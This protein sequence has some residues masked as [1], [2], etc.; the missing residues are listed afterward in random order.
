MSNEEQK[1][2]YIKPILVAVVDKQI[3]Q[4]SKMQVELLGTEINP[5]DYNNIS[6]MIGNLKEYMINCRSYNGNKNKT[7]ISIVRKI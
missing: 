2:K 6:E 1:G 7:R 5:D 4:L 3:K